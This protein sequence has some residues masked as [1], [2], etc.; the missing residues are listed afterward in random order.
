MSALRRTGAFTACGARHRRGRATNAKAPGRPRRA[1]AH[2][3]HQ[4]PHRSV[5][6]SFGLGFA[7]EVPLKFHRACRRSGPAATLRGC[8]NDGS[9]TSVSTHLLWKRFGYLLLRTC[10]TALTGPG[11]PLVVHL[12]GDKG[13]VR[14]AGAMVRRLSDVPLPDPGCTGPSEALV[15]VI[16]HTASACSQTR[17]RRSVGAA[18]C[19]SGPERHRP[20]LSRAGDRGGR[21]ERG[22][23]A[24]YGDTRRGRLRCRPCPRCPCGL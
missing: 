23:R 5:D 7:R 15:H 11:D 4:Q 19:H 18:C 22:H 16:T 14:A 13:A 3:E 24:G 12:R 8:L 20:D 2:L 21:T 17:T 6:H 1:S 10:A 9:T